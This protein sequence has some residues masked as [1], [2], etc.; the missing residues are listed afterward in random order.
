MSAR[1][2]ASIPADGSPSFQFFTLPT[3]GANPSGITAGPDGNL[4]FTEFGTNQIGR[5]TTL[6]I[7]TEF[8]P[9]SGSPDR[10]AAGPDGNLWFTEP[11]PF[12]R[13]IG[14]ITTAGVI[15]EFQL[16]DG[17]QPRGIVAGPDGNLWFT[18]YG[19][20]ALTRMSPAGVVIDSE[21]VRDGPWGIG[22]GL[23]NTIW[24]TQIDG[25]RVARFAIAP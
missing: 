9:V 16:A 19:A 10:I 24:L 7:I 13:R 3:L 8:G 1:S 11:F 20:G 6:G 21:R 17:S 4:W 18:D 5:I 25:N 22:R 12:D 2:L 15:T 23:G 14:R